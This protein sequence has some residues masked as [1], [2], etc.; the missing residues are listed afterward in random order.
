MDYE[1]REGENMKNGEDGCSEMR[2]EKSKKSKKKRIRDGG[3]KWKRD[4]MG[5]GTKRR[6]L[7]WSDMLLSSGVWRADSS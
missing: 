3:I 1:W 2:A 6:R 5:K 7:R 4:E